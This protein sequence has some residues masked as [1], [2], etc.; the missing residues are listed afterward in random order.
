MNDFK[1]YTKN[2]EKNR[3]DVSEFIAAL[4]TTKNENLVKSADIINKYFNKKV[5]K[6]QALHDLD[7]LVDDSILMKFG[8]LNRFKVMKHLI[9]SKGEKIMAQEE[10]LESFLKM[11][12][13]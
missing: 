7:K 12:L 2:K 3:Y 11:L 9:F 1:D 10:N 6:E 13:G 5:K 8:L 4:N